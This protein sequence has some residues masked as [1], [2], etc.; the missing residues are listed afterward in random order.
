MCVC[1]CLFQDGKIT[2]TF[3]VSR[4][5]VLCHEKC[6]RHLAVTPSGN[7]LVSGGDDG[8]VK[9]WVVTSSTLGTPE[10]ATNRQ[11]HLAHR[12]TVHT[13][14]GPITNLTIKQISREVSLSCFYFVRYFIWVITQFFLIYITKSVLSSALLLYFG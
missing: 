1:V 6:V 3:Q 12:R 2:C 9:V 7:H 14:R 4:K 13:G 5:G 11:P 8:E 10:A